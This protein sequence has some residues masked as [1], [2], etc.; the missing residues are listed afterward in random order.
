MRGGET[1]LKGPMSHFKQLIGF[2][3][4]VHSVSDRSTRTPAADKRSTSS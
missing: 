3:H 2:R 1:I 4:R